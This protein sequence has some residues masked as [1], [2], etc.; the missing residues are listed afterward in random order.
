MTFKTYFH[1]IYSNIRLYLY[2]PKHRHNVQL[3][4]LTFKMLET[5]TIQYVMDLI[6]TKLIRSCAIYW[7][8]GSAITDISSS[9]SLTC[10]TQWFF[11][12]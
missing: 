8:K 12:C 1:Y 10:L 3:C 6:S 2:L 4:S 9:T 7:M 5:D 11:L